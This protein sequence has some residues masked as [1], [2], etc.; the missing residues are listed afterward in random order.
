MKKEVKEEKPNLFRAVS[1]VKYESAEEEPHAADLEDRRKRKQVFKNGNEK[2]ANS[3]LREESNLNQPWW[4][5][6]MESAS[7][8]E[9]IA[10]LCRY[11]CPKCRK[12]YTNRRS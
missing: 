8:S 7:T 6:A 10:N 12:V 2:F 4:E 5:K 1:E 3:D 9:A 11:K